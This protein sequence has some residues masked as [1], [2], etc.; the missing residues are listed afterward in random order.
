HLIRAD[1]DG[2]KG[3]LLYFRLASVHNLRFLVKLVAGA[4][5]AI[6]DGTFPAYRQRFM[7]AFTPPD[8]AVAA[9]QR[10]KRA[11]RLEA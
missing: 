1:D 3:E 11:E 9:E 5:D 4:R 10:R 2:A 6:L 8:Q 7:G